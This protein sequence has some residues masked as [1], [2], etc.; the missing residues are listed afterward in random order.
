MTIYQFFV[1]VRGKSKH[2]TYKSMINHLPVPGGP[3]ACTGTH[4][5]LARILAMDV[6]RSPTLPAELVAAADDVSTSRLRSGRA[7]RQLGGPLHVVEPVRDHAHVHAD[8]TQLLDERLLE[9]LPNGALQPQHH[10]ERGLLACGRR[11]RDNCPSS[12]PNRVENGSRGL[13]I[14][15]CKVV[16][17]FGSAPQPPREPGASRKCIVL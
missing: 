7:W 12:K 11:V 13:E 14:E 3:A 9:L 16:L 17:Q 4:H 6:L 1:P 10:L 8:G 15:C 5:I 2:I